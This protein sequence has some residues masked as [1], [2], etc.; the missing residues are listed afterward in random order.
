MEI[1]LPQLI[2]NLAA[3]LVEASA[4]VSSVSALLGPVT[5]KYSGSGYYLAPADRRLASIWA[6]IQIDEK[7]ES[8]A[9]VDLELRTSTLSMAELD[10]RFGAFTN[11]PP[12]PSGPLYRIRYGFSRDKKPY[13][14]AIFAT[15]S[16][17]PALNSPVEK[18][19]LRRD[20]R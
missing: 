11:M 19:M 2:E 7:G 8:L 12:A 4:S 5:E 9:S 17:E 10:Q 6:A 3:H 14:V 18:V 20:K 16:D 13:T 1:P 15:L